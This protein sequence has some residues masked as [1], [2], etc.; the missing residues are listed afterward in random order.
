MVGTAEWHWPA[1]TTLVDPA[2][3]N[4]RRARDVARILNSGRRGRN[5][6]RI[7]LL[8]PSPWVAAEN[9]YVGTF[10]ENKANGGAWLPR[11]FGPARN[12]VQTGEP[13][14]NSNSIELNAIKQEQIQ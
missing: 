6:Q 9:D 14:P 3:V 7:V 1:A 12:T 11:L 10:A 8:L 5:R 13:N 4:P 2:W